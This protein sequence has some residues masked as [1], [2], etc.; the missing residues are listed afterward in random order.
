MSE[1]EAT[2]NQGLPTNGATLRSS[3]ETYPPAAALG[4]S[5]SSFFEILRRVFSFP[6][7]L[8]TLLVGGVYLSAREFMVDPDC[9]WH[10]KTGEIILATHHWP[11]GD[12]YS[13]TVAGHPWL[14]YEWGG[15][16]LLAIAERLGGVR[17]LSAFLIIVAAAVMI[18]LYYLGTLC[19][20]KS[21]AGLVSATVLLFLAVPS[22]SLR[23]QMLGY[24]FLILTLIAL[25]RFRQ[26]KHN[27]LWLLPI[28]FLVWVNTH[29]SWIIGLGVIG[30]YWFAGLFEF[31][32]GGLEARRWSQPD[33][34]RLSSVFL[35]SLC[36]L[37]ITPYG[38]ALCFYPLQ[39]ASS[40]PISVAGIMEWQ[41]MPFNLPGGKL[42]L[43]LLLGFVV[44]QIAFRFVW[45][46]ETLA[47]F[48][49]G[50]AMATLHVRF[51]LL[52]VPFFA[53][54]LAIIVARWL[55]PYNR[56]K[57]QFV[58]NAVLM[59]GCIAAMVH[60]FPSRTELDTSLAEGFP[61]G[62]VEYLN[63]HDVPEPMMNSY[64]F[65]GYLIWSRG[66][67]HKVFVDGRSEL[68]EA[69]GLLNDYMQLVTI[70]PAALSILRFYGIKS[71]LLGRNEQLVTVL[72]ALPEWQKV[73]TDNNSVIFVQRESAV[74]Q[75]TSRIPIP[76][77][78]E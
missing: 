56:A 3:A 10:I 44:A 13:Y 60:Y 54:V 19:S 28:L 5:T 26:G 32:M 18:A 53:P 43:A 15:D 63:H 11:H 37:P 67:E 75:A 64:G 25:E 58:L 38:S 33:R 34:Q 68:Y 22:F 23:P 74:A 59:A 27:A 41:P 14:A 31:Q 57:D 1:S 9:W 49:F 12:P 6:A 71:L 8:G 35:L 77:G 36:A 52:F 17:G 51:V 55:S 46:L 7:M 65:G 30:V 20:G 24:L 4:Q 78:Q 70:K 2:V 40:I 42:F 39:V 45:R 29:G 50:T 61:I 16:V 48:L 62:A 73:Y 47:L 69:G 76:A 21:K 72:N 66:P